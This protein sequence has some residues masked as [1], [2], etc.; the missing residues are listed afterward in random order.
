MLNALLREKACFSL[1][2]LAV[3]GDDML[4]LGLQGRAVGAALDACLAAVLDGVMPN[5][6]T[7]LLSYAQGAGVLPV[8]S[9]R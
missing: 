9:G 1:R 2:D 3:N 5:E 4:R 6:R 8:S 7:A